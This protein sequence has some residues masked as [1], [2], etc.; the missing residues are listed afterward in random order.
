MLNISKIVT[1][2]TIIIIMTILTGEHSQ[3]QEQDE[4]KLFVQDG[5]SYC[6]E[7]L[8]F[9][10]ENSLTDKY[11]IEIYDVKDSDGNA[12][13]F[14]EYLDR[15]NYPNRY[16]PMLYLNGECSSSSITVIEKLT[17]FAG[18]EATTPIGSN[19]SENNDSENSDSVNQNNYSTVT[20]ENDATTLSQALNDPSELPEIP[21][22][23]Y[24]ILLVSFIALG[25]ISY[26]IIK[27]LKI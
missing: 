7:V 12:T 15:C 26:I 2:V 20:N 16:V 24:P 10:D 27:K 19:N 9:I 8:S 23:A 14:T 11:N 5:C 25:A 6:E 13:L 18:L 3:A 17:A 1:T 21:W 22:Y 4:I